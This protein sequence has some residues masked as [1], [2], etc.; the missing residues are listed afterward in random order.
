MEPLRAPFHRFMGG[1]VRGIVRPY[2][3]N[4]FHTNTGKAEDLAHAVMDG[5]SDKSSVPAA[6]TA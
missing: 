2:L 6:S 5:V 1:N 3:I 4:H